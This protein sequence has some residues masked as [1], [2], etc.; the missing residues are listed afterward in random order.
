[1]S[2]PTATELLGE[3]PEAFDHKPGVTASAQ[4][5]ITLESITVHLATHKGVRSPSML[6]AQ[7]LQSR[8]RGHEFHGGSRVSRGCSVV[9]DSV[10]VCA[11]FSHDHADGVLGNAVGLH[12]VNNRGG[13]R[14]GVGGT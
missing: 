3:E 11:D 1:M 5:Q 9:T 7:Q 12:Q 6:R 8:R 14:C 4:N 10:L 2:D 13:Q